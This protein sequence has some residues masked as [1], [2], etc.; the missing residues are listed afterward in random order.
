MDNAAGSGS[1]SCWSTADGWHVKTD[2]S[3]I[4]AF[5]RGLH[6][7]LAGDDGRAFGEELRETRTEGFAR[8]MNAMS[9]NLAIE[10]NK[11]EFRIKE[12]PT[13]AQVTPRAGSCV[14][15]IIK[16][17][18]D[19]LYERAERSRGRPEKLLTSS[20]FVGCGEAAEDLSVQYKDELKET[21]PAKHGH[22]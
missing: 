6:K 10:L 20:G 14:S 13:V 22:R 16:Q 7:P 4:F 11:L 5:A 21:I 12:D 17:A 1:S 9:E 8:A 19:A 15:N 2:D 18:I 3:L